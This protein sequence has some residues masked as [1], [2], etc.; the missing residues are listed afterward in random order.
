A[1]FVAAF[2]L[3]RRFGLIKGFQTYGDVMP[4]Y[5]TG[6]TANERPGRAVV[7][8]AID[9]L[10]TRRAQR[11]FLWVHLFE[12]H[13]PYGDPGQTGRPAIERYDDDIAE[14]DRQ[15]GRLLDALGDL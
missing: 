5:P 12:P 1:G 9:W 4:R 15:V 6:R 3:D 10:S 13:A 2:P 7:D 8:E 14:A 11:F